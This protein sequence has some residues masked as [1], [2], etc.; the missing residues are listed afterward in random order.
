M[1]ECH[2]S[3]RERLVIIICYYVQDNT[4]LS[5]IYLDAKRLCPYWNSCDYSDWDLPLP[6]VP[7]LLRG[8]GVL[9]ERSRRGKR[10]SCFR[11]RIIKVNTCLVGICYL[12]EE[13]NKVQISAF[14]SLTL[15]KFHFSPVHPS[16][17]VSKFI[18]LKLIHLVMLAL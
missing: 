6:G 1:K 8:G 2:E 17:L 7:V 14:V 11:Y 4:H 5:F 18:S 16:L 15:A 12:I 10:S 13:H 9:K 3:L